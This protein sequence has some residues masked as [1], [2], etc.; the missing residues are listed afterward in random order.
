MHRMQSMAAIKRFFD[1]PVL[2]LAILL[3][4]C[5]LAGGCKIQMGV[6]TRKVRT[7]EERRPVSATGPITSDVQMSP[8]DQVVLTLTRDQKEE[9]ST[10]EW[11][12]QF[13]RHFDLSGLFI[14][15]VLWG[16]AISLSVLRKREGYEPD[17]MKC[18]S[19][20]R[21]F[22]FCPK[23]QKLRKENKPQ[24]NTDEK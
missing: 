4:V 21:C 6:K 5:L 3:S 15:L 23:E 8:G 2:A 16:K 19:C 22:E 20:A 7:D 13:K 1:S 11:H 24:I 10:V 17:K 9:V 12:Q 14:G 18:V